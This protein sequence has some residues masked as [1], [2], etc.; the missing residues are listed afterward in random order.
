M[1]VLTDTNIVIDLAFVGL[2]EEFFLRFDDVYME[3]SVYSSEIVQPKKFS[4]DLVSLGLNLTTIT[5]EELI[6]AQY[7]RQETRPL[8]FQDGA[9]FA[10]CKSRGWTLLT[11]DKAL[12]EHSKKNEV[13]VHGLV[14]VMKMC[15]DRGTPSDMIKNAIQT[16]LGLESKRI[17]EKWFKQLLPE[18][19]E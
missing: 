1:V 9:S 4:K 5:A 19:F 7:A 6:V 3:E 2:L 16:Y 12:R 15:Q 8:S 10:I 14:W 17:D 18:Y 11:G 13:E